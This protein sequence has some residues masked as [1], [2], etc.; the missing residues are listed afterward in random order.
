MRLGQL[1]RQL[2]ITPDKIVS[3]LGSRDIALDSS[4]NARVDDAYVDL[5]IQH[6]APGNET[7]REQI[8]QQTDTTSVEPAVT[9]NSTVEPLPEVIKA[10]KVE[11]PGLR[12]V[13]KIELPE[14]KKKEPE[15][16]GEE[17]SP[18]P[19]ERPRTVSRNP[20]RQQPPRERSNPIALAR[21]REEQE[22]RKREAEARERE[23]QRKAEFYQKRLKPQPPTKA[24]RLHRE[25][26]VEM[27]PLEPEKPRS[28][29]GRFLHWLND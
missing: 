5:I 4:A 15:K 13:G 17:A 24:A 25:E 27:P 26:V 14:K 6:F 7:L 22:K 3:F 21:Q 1:A 28:L 11:L 12:V 16:S 9:E 19:E 29:W 23:K 10:P 2:D 20:R 18:A 8:H